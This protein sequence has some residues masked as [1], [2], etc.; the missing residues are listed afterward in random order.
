MTAGGRNQ[1]AEI[2]NGVPELPGVYAFVDQRGRL[3]YIG[4]SVN[5]RRRMVGYLTRDPMKVKPAHGLLASSIRGFSW[6]HTRTELMAL[7]L[8]DA[9]IKESMPP[10]NSRQRDFLENRYLELTDDRFPSCVIVEHVCDFGQREVYGP[11]R[12]RYQAAS[13]RDAVHRIIGMRTCTEAEPT[14]T[15]LDHDIGRCTGPCRGG[16]KPDRYR[17]LVGAARDFLNGEADFV[18]ERLAKEME[19]AVAGG[20]YEEAERLRKTIR[21][22]ASFAERQRFHRRFACGR[23]SLGSAEDGTGYTFEDGAL[24]YP[25]SVVLITG[26]GGQSGDSGRDR[27]DPEEAVRRALKALREVPV[28]DRRVLAD[29]ERIVYSWLSKRRAGQDNASE[30]AVE[31]RCV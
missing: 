19:R 31:D 16:L 18:L 5:L 9:L 20:R 21:M 10:L 23:F 27:F 22:A 8:E 4:K 14:N 17:E 2:R 25:R 11:L 30:R 24:V 15:C 7:L 26:H 28:S 12:D 1:A 6:W 3:L 13:L 29:R